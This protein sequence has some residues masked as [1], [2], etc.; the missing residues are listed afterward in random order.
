[1]AI[2]GATIGKV[3]VFYNKEIE[4][5]TLSADTAY[6][7]FNN[8]EDSIAYLLY[9][10]T[11]IGQLA[12]TQ[13]ITGATNKHLAIE[14]IKNIVLPQFEDSIKK[15]VKNKI[16]QSMDNIYTSKQL[17]QEAKQ[18]VEDLIEGKFDTSKLNN[19]SSTE[20]RC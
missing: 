4:K 19:D 15:E 13:G 3:S 20:S 2:T 7:R 9:F 6:V 5:A 18:D 17:I 12:I 8:I 16:V 10:K 1:M 11:V 14:D